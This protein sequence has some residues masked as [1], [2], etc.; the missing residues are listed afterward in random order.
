MCRPCWQG[1]DEYGFLGTT[2][3][4]VSGGQ[5]LDIATSRGGFVGQFKAR[6]M[7]KTDPRLLDGESGLFSQEKTNLCIP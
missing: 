2:L 5:V 3:S 1:A 7:Q 6:N 4:G